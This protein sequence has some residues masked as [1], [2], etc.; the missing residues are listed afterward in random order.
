MQ[1]EGLAMEAELPDEDM[2]LE[3]KMDAIEFTDEGFLLVSEMVVE[4]LVTES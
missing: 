1:D 2:L 3:S 4:S